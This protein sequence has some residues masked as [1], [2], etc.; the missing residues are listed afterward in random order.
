MKKQILSVIAALVFVCF[1][2]E[3]IPTMLNN[4]SV[5]WINWDSLVGRHGFYFK[6]RQWLADLRTI[7]AAFRYLYSSHT[8]S[9]TN[10]VNISVP[11]SLPLQSEITTNLLGIDG[12]ESCPLLAGKRL[13]TAERVMG[14]NRWSSFDRLPPMLAFAESSSNGLYGV[15]FSRVG[16]MSY[17]PEPG[18]SPLPRLPQRAKVDQ[19]ESRS[20][21]PDLIATN[22]QGT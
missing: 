3:L 4:T 15:R 1:L 14:R 16:V 9:P 6:K 17:F 8:A 20:S 19:T 21:P 5:A 22:L 2:T 18:T 7:M 11:P 10:L 13:T 12:T